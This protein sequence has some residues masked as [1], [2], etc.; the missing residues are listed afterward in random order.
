MIAI[1]Y[2]GNPLPNF[3]AFCQQLQK[4]VGNWLRLGYVGNRRSKIAMDT[5]ARKFFSYLHKT[6]VMKIAN[7]PAERLERLIDVVE[8]AFPQLKADRIAK[9]ANPRANVSALYECIYK[10]FSNY[11]YDSDSFPSEELMEDLGLTVCP[12][13]NRNFIK[14][15]KVK[16][17]A[18]GKDIYVKGQLDH[19]YPRALYPYLA[20]SRYNLVPSCPSC[21]GASGKHDEDTKT[22]GVVNPYTLS[23]SSGLK[24]KM[25][26]SGK[27]FANLETC[28][29]AISIDVDYSANPSLAINEDIFHLKKLYSSHTDY[30][31][32]IYFKSILRMPQ[33]YKRVI[34]K[35]MIAKGMKYTDD[36]FRRFLLGVYI[37]EEEFHKRPLSKFCSDIARQNHL[38]P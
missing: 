32:E 35:K 7:Y 8:W 26:I 24:F 33:V 30:A 28:A 19:F 20:I 16:Q 21:N 14:T 15:I 36:D 13:C 25:S 9:K 10:A 34:G 23:D 5:D 22:K 37:K 12:Y 6:S 27:G 17:N 1:N 2:S 29:K 31:A 11:G 3:D 4:K 38:I 18:Q